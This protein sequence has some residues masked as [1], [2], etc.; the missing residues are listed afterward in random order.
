MTNASFPP[1]RRGFFGVDGTTGEIQLLDAGGNVIDL[2]AGVTV[3]SV[4][5]PADGSDGEIV[6]DGE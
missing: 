1:K 3:T 2:P 6:F 5:N 4:T